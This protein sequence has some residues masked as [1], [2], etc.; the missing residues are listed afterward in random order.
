MLANGSAQYLATIT[1]RDSSP[2]KRLMPV[3]EV[4]LVLPAGSAVTAAPSGPYITDEN[5]QVSVS[6]TSSRPGTYTVEAC[7]GGGS[8]TPGAKEIEFE[9]VRVDLS[10]V[11][12]WF[13]V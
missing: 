1:V 5:G 12:T 4:T 11:N 13:A 6:F 8:I 10:D 3:A 9:A 2:A 7:V